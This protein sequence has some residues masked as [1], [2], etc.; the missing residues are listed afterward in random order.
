MLKEVF[1][2]TTT[3]TEERVLYSNFDS[4]A[5]AILRLQFRCLLS[6]EKQ[7]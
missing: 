3:Q 4:Q 7:F 5:G 1:I 6:F 2:E